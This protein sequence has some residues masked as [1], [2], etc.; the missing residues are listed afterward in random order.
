MFVVVGEC[1]RLCPDVGG[2]STDQPAQGNE[3][4]YL[5]NWGYETWSWGIIMGC[6]SQ[7]T[8]ITWRIDAA[9]KSNYSHM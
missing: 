3:S 6:S 2:L 4:S 1:Y 8:C 7:A 9:N 5:T